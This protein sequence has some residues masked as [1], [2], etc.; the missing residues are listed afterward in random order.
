[1]LT[2]IG[3]PNKAVY[4]LGQFK[5]GGRRDPAL[6]A[7]IDFGHMV[8]ILPPNTLLLLQETP[9]CSHGTLSPDYS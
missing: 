7:A 3:P 6:A 2:A 1:M 4:L 9:G 5:I 8:M